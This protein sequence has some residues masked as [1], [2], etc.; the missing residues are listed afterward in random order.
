LRSSER[1]V[2]IGRDGRPGWRLKTP[3]SD[4]NA[5]RMPLSGFTLPTLLRA[6][7]AFKAGRL[8]GGLEDAPRETF[9]PLE[10]AF[11]LFAWAARCNRDSLCVV[12]RY[13]LDILRIERTI[14]P[15]V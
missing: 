15:P 9:L 13:R 2:A 8:A 7:G 4:V 5:E 6:G 3:R 10:G 12:L 11:L 14:C 1:P